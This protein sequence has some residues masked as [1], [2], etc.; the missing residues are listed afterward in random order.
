MATALRSLR[1]E[2]E[3]LETKQAATPLAGRITAVKNAITALSGTNSGKPR[4]RMS[5]A[6]REKL[7]QA[8]LR[9]WHG[10]SK[11]ASKS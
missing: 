7:R 8:G 11:A 9:R 6:T 10:K 4:R 1:R 2:L 3:A 5:A